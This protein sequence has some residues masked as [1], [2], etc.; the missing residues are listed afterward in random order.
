MVGLG[1]PGRGDHGVGPRVLQ[2]MRAGP[3]TFRLAPSQDMLSLL[4]LGK[5][6]PRVIIVDAARS[7]GEPGAV[8]T[9][10]LVGPVSQAIRRG[11]TNVLGPFLHGVDLSQVL[12]M[13]DSMGSLPEKITLYGVVGQ[14]FG[15][16]APLS[17]AVEAT[18]RELALLL[19]YEL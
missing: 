9:L 14:N 6:C 18:A 19:S 4:D 15:R 16:G 17:P 8:L 3:D 7:G 13:A 12:M 1:D 5:A 2:L 10:E 11:G